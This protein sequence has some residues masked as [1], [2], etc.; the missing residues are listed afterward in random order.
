MITRL[1]EIDF[2]RGIAILL[3]VIF[4]IAFDLAHFFNWSLDYQ[5]GFWYFQG[6]TAAV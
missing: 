3:M 1:T 2:L 6:K 5:N 4:H